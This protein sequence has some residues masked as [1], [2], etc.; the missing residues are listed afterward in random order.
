MSHQAS[1]DTREGDWYS[2]SNAGREGQFQL[3]D[4]AVRSQVARHNAS[5][6]NAFC[7][8][9]IITQL[10]STTGRESH[11]SASHPRQQKYFLIFW[12]IINLRRRLTLALQ[13]IASPL[14]TRSEWK[15]PRQCTWHIRDPGRATPYSRPGRSRSPNRS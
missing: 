1:R 14:S 9:D 10:F 12:K 13:S 8:G 11:S 2:L 15:R 3:N 6:Q 5:R 4:T 7:S